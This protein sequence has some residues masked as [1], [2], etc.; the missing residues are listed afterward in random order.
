MT[1][2]PSSSAHPHGTYGA[3]CREVRLWD[4]VPGGGT[5]QL[6]M[7]DRILVP[8][9]L[10]TDADRALPVAGALA[11][12]LGVPV[13][14]LI[15]TSKGVDPRIDE[16]EAR[17][18]ARAAGCDLNAVELRTDDDVADG[19][20]AAAG[21]PATL[22]CLATHARGAVADL[23]VRSTGER[24]IRRAAHPVLAVGP[25]TVIDPPPCANEI[26]CCVGDD[27]AQ[28]RRL[29]SVTAAWAI[30]LVCDPW[31]VHV[32]DTPTDGPGDGSP[33]RAVLDELTHE[34]L[35]H[36]MAATWHVVADADTTAGI[37][38]FASTLSDPVLI[39]ASHGRAGLRRLA[40]GSVTLDVVRRSPHPVL[41]VPARLDHGT[42]G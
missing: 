22:L 42:T 25:R 18:H 30:H 39:M 29:L 11:H 13:D 4:S 38:R 26:V 15:V 27:Q 8:L 28:A 31:L 32:A 34:L 12:K 7:L 1:T 21:S 14:A 24:V 3:A 6:M 2:I 17:W 19:I 35:E 20:L 10:G 9:D 23:A 16:H 37:L 41:V 33:D 36:G 40:L 5:L